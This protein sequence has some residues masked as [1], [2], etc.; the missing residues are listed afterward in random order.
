MSYLELDLIFIL[1][2][3]LIS[4]EKGIPVFYN[5]V[6]VGCLEG[7]LL[8]LFSTLTS[9]NQFCDSIMKKLE[10]W[11]P[12]FDSLSSELMKVSDQCSVEDL[13]Q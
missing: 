8:K 2:Q 4:T 11:L 13:P 5:Y 1:S 3:S 10:S 9:I 7:D 12:R 6:S